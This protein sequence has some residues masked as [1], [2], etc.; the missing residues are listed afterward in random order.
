MKVHKI[1]SILLIIFLPFII[2]MAGV[3]L[4]ISPSFAVVEYHRAGFP[5]DPY[6]FT[7]EQ[8]EA[9]SAYAITYLVNDADISYLGSLEDDQ[10]QP[11][12]RESELEHMVDVKHVVRTSLT[13]WYALIGFS[14]A[15]SIW[16]IVMRQGIWLVRA[17]RWGGWVTLFLILGMLV[18]IALS[19]NQLFDAFHRI[20]FTEGTWLFFE[21][22]TLIRLFPMVF[23]RDAF[24]FVGGFTLLV[25]VLLVVLTRKR[26][27][28]HSPRG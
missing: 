13:V 9:Y 27:S 4:L 16:L 24:I 6:G 12:F 14:L 8:R 19:F 22:D 21:S 26:K 7:Q 28:V 1:V 18:A 11:I 23:W 25:G 20:F 10:G 5:S 15:A 2:L 3:R 17:L